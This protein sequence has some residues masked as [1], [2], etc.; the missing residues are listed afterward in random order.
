MWQITQTTLTLR[1]NA[2]NC[3]FRRT[4]LFYMTV[5]NLEKD[6]SVVST[7]LSKLRKWIRNFRKLHFASTRCTHDSTFRTNTQRS[8]RS[9]QIYISVKRS[10]QIIFQYFLFSKTD[11]HAI[12][13]KFNQC[14]E[15][16]GDR[17]KHI[18]L[19]RKYEEEIWAGASEMF[20]E[21]LGNKLVYS[22]SFRG[23][24]ILSFLLLQVGRQSPC[25]SKLLVNYS[26]SSTR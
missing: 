8:I 18:R 9:L 20:N 7:K 1:K 14:H 22:R 11:W 6:S 21:L 17:C 25:P 10:L 13:S 5:S 23:A 24:W 2:S 3:L 19:Y 16:R 12:F 26:N 4:W 15:Y